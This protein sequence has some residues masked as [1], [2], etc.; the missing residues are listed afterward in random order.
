MKSAKKSFFPRMIHKK[1]TIVI[2]LLAIFLPTLIVG[3]LSFNTFTKRRESVSRLLESSLWTSGQAAL[4][5]LEGRLFEYEEQAL[6]PENYSTLDNSSELAGRHFILDEDYQI[7]FPKS[8]S[9]ESSIDSFKQELSEPRFETFF[10]GAGR[11]EFSLKDYLRA[12]EE[13]Q[14]SLE[15]ASSGQNQAFALEGLARSFLLSGNFDRA[16]DT[17]DKLAR[18]YGQLKNKA[19]H[20]YGLVAALQLYDIHKDQ[21]NEDD[22]LKTLLDAYGK[23]WNGAWPLNFPTFG[24]FISEMD[25]LLIPAFE[26]QKF[27]K[28]WE[29]YKNLI[30]VPSSFLLELQ[31]TEFLNNDVVPR[32]RERRGFYGSG[33]ASQPDR[34]LTS[35]DGNLQFI[36]YRLLPPSKSEETFFGGFIWDLD[37]L[38]SEVLPEMLKDVSEEFGLLLSVLD[39]KTGITSTEREGGISDDSLSLSFRNILLPW[40]LIAS[41][42]AFQDL[43]KTARREKFFYGIL[44]GVIIILM[45]IGVLLIVRDVSRETETTQL[46]TEF[47][48]NVSHELKT[49]LTLIRLYGETLQRKENLSKKDRY[50]AYEIITKESERLSHMINNILDF[51]RIEM[52]R[53]E[54]DFKKG[55]IADV[56]RN[57]LDSY[58]YHLEKKGFSIEEEIASDLP[59][60]VFDKEAIASVLI[61]LLSNAIKFSPEQK[62]VRV[63]VYRKDE[64]IGFQ[65]ADQGIG[66]SPEARSKIFER[67]YRLQNRTTSESQGSGLG[68]TL[69]KHIVEAHGGKICVDSEPEKGSVFSVYIP[70]SAALEE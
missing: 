64:S 34:F 4:Q 51:S 57:T 52:G 50:E 31:F 53:K 3:Y 43:Q 46:K 69:V 12:T 7:V 45:F 67:F 24:F 23:L 28:M 56:I 26:N 16:R 32:I 5:T 11:Y 37:L 18:D 58:R 6:R 63:T 9:F 15:A 20:P 17:Y 22:G 48:H 62:E 27:H 40:K 38:K 21:N 44:L 1:K 49:P 30:A 61:N 14:K 2:F 60:I 29:K 59:D 65:V 68:L 25:S 70:I 42:D 39:E 36:S 54:F 10:T 55:N 8:V 13:Y 41:L 33:E 19:G 35:S 66:I 47:V